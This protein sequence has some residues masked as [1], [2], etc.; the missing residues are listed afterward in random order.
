MVVSALSV[1]V[2]FWPIF[3]NDVDHAAERIGA[4]KEDI[5]PRT[6]S[7]RS[8]AS[9]GIQFRSKSLWRKTALRELTRFPSTRIRV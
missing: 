8:M 5:G 3:G 9:T 4:V 6:T 7:I 2:H 1:P